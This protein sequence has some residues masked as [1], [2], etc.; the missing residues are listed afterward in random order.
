MPEPPQLSPFD[1]EE[2]QLYSELFPGD[3]APYPISKGA[4]RHPTEEA[5]FGRLYLGSY[6][7]GHDPELMI[8]VVIRKTLSGVNLWKSANPDT[9]LGQ[10]YKREC[11]DQLYQHV[12]RKLPSL[13]LQDLTADEKRENQTGLYQTG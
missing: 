5:H 3:R 6:P 1:V 13:R 12:V 10:R 11:P 2:Q 7:F 4:P 9:M 8:I